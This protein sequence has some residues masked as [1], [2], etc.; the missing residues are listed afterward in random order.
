M[1]DNHIDDEMESSFAISRA[2]IDVHVGAYY[3]CHGKIYQ[4][5]SP[6]SESSVIGIDVETNLPMALAIA[7]LRPV[8]EGSPTSGTSG[9]GDPSIGDKN[10]NIAVKRFDAIRPFINDPSPGAKAVAEVAAKEGVDSSTIYRWL[11]KYRLHRDVAC[12]CPQPRGWQKGNSRLS[13]DQDQVIRRVINEYHLQ[14]QRPSVIRTIEKVEEECVL[15]GIKLPGASAI[16]ARIAQVSERRRLRKRGQQKLADAKF[17]ATP[18]HYP[19]TT[20][21]LQVV[22]IDHT[23]VD[24]NTVDDTHRLEIGRF[25]GTYAIDVYTRALVGLYLSFDPPSQTSVAMC[26]A[27]M[28]TS[29]VRSSKENGVYANLPFY[30]IPRRLHLDNGSEFHGD[31]FTRS[32]KKYGIEVTYRPVKVPRYGSHIER[33][34]GTFMQKTHSLPGTTFSSIKERGEYDPSKYAALTL[35]EY[36]KWLLIEICKIYH[37]KH[38]S[39]IGMSPAEKWRRYYLNPNNNGTPLAPSLPVDEK[40]VLIDFL[41]IFDRTVQNNGVTIDDVTYYDDILRGWIG[42]TDPND[43]KKKRTFE[44]RRDPRDISAVWFD[45]P[46]TKSYFRISASSQPFP[47]CSIWDWNKAKRILAAENPKNE[48]RVDL[49][50]ARIEQKLLVEASIANTKKQRRLN[51]RRR[52]HENIRQQQDVLEPPK[53]TMPVSSLIDDA[54]SSEKILDGFDDIS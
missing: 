41:E 42:A 1:A 39:G 2:R 9:I 49:I 46:V 43:S 31:S 18:G 45:D 15:L 33:L 16:R 50:K 25:W 34:I 3:E 6:S 35:A 36:G 24:L 47:N 38:H 52:D 14:P 27:S 29:K 4:I 44:F 26:M 17:L 12:L 21:P 54:E 40:T 19:E 20:F 48:M 11:Q 30:G 53:K 7:D 8:I 10:W 51:Q 32:C 23:F 5:D 22:Q 13:E 37:V 28:L